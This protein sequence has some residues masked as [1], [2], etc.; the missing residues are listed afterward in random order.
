MG[1]KKLWI[2][3]KTDQALKPVF[4]RSN[5]MYSTF[6]IAIKIFHKTLESN[7]AFNFSDWFGGDKYPVWSCCSDCP[8]RFDWLIDNFGVDLILDKTVEGKYQI[9]FEKSE[10]EQIKILCNR[11][12][13]VR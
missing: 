5:T 4:V 6:E 13:F 11:I 9:E 3:K 2:S 10:N 8:T 1:I 12:T 7:I